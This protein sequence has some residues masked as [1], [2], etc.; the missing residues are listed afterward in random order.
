MSLK[1]TAINTFAATA[2]ISLPTDKPGVWIEGSFT[3]RFNYLPNAEVNAFL[4]GLNELKRDGQ[5]PRLTE[6]LEFQHA[7]I[8]RAL[9]A[10]EGISDDSGNL[11]PAAALELVLGNQSL[12]VEALNAF[13][14]TYSGAAAKN[15]KPS[16]KR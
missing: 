2:H 11:E 10:V 14:T 8:K 7:F 6:S 9:Y 4:D 12:W 5:T 13:I 3:C 16:Q 15:S 1:I